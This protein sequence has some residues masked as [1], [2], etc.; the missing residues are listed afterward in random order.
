MESQLQELTALVKFYEKKIST[1]ADQQIIMPQVRGGSGFFGME[2]YWEGA[3]SWMGTYRVP[4]SPFNHSHL[5][6]GMQDGVPGG[7][8]SDEWILEE[9]VSCSPPN[10]SHL[11]GAA[12]R[13][14]RWPLF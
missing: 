8:S 10:H 2:A 9:H 1:L 3:R 13:R 14:A 11:C 7:P 4:P 6:G 5:C 12:G